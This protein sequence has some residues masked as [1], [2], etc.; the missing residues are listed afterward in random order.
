MTDGQIVIG[1]AAADDD[2][3]CGRAELVPTHLPPDKECLTSDLRRDK[4]E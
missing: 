2:A 3:D 4:C 1:D